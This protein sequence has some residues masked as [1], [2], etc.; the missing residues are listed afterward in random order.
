MNSTDHDEFDACMQALA[1]VHAFLHHEMT[2]ADAD[3]LRHHLHACE[4][5][6]EN[7]DVEQAITAML[8]RCCAEPKA[9]AQ[10]RLTITRT[11][12]HRG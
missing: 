2:E 10:L 11:I 7:F 5:C 8:R 9:P 3:L 4:R 6:M 12:I 1:N